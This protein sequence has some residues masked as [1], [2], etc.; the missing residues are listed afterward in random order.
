MELVA[1]RMAR[2]IPPTATLATEA[3]VAPLM[4]GV[5]TCSSIINSCLV[6]ETRSGA[7]G[8]LDDGGDDVFIHCE[9]V[10]RHRGAA[11]G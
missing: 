6:T 4:M 5:T 9:T 1:L 3:L 2:M 11:T 7:G 8:T 10:G